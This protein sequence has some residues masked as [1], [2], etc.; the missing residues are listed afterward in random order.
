L[1]NLCHT[2]TGLALGE[3]GLKRRAPFANATLMV[4]ANLPDIDVL[5]FATDVPAVA[6]RRGWT[7]G[8]IAQVGLPLALASI[9]YA[10]ARRRRAD[11]RPVD[12]GWILL[13]SQIGVLSHVGLDWLNNYGVRLLM[14]LS[15]R[16]FY[17]DSVFII[18]IWLW[19]ML[20]AGVWMARKKSSVRPARIAIVMAAAYI[21][22]QVV[23][24][25]DSRQFVADVWL[26]RH[27]RAPVA[28]MVGPQ[29][30]T[31]IDRTIIL[32]D[33]DE[34]VTGAFRSTTRSA[35]FDAVRVAKNDTHPAVR[36]AIAQDPRFRAVLTWARFPY[37]EIESTPEGEVVTLRDLRFGERVGG[38]R[39][40]VARSSGSSRPA[41]PSR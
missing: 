25:R 4:A 12:F 27:G 36:A 37:Y 26:Q 39:A 35:A 7:H 13:L 21:A 40:V 9:V 34:Y 15:P 22:A 2:L 33:G 16:W 8:I 14:P 18:D 17:G 20:G 1:D 6:F 31:P 32:D 3:A 38:V 23:L 29:P 30:V 41:G 19:A 10:I 5:V 24:A 28:L 11:L